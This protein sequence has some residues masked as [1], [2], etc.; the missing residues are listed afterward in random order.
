MSSHIRTAHSHAPRPRCTLT[1]CAPPRL[2][3]SPPHHIRTPRTTMPFPRRDVPRWHHSPPHPHRRTHT[4]S[5]D[6]WQHR[7][8][9]H[10]H[11]APAHRTAIRRIRAAPHPRRIRPAMSRPGCPAPPRRNA[12]QRG[13]PLRTAALHP[14]RTTPRPH[15][16]AL[17]PAA[18]T[19]AAPRPPPAAP[20]PA[21]PAATRRPWLQLGDASQKKGPHRTRPLFRIC[22]PNL[23]RPQTGHIRV[24]SPALVRPEL[25]RRLVWHGWTFASRHHES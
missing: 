4:A 2:N 6:T 11:G 7:A 14:H 23:S 13:A 18:P 22:C 10:P 3:P 15:R 17:G 9:L 19:P 12:S 25:R 21:A 8:P 16:N 1:H 5:F 24:G 20:T